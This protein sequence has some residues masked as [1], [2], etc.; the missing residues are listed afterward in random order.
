MEAG[1]RLA[2][3][4]HADTRDYRHVDRVAPYLGNK[5]LENRVGGETDCQDDSR[6]SDR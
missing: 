6:N 2:H 3:T 1:I 5:D 4:G